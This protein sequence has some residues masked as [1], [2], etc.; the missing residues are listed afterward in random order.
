MRSD[1]TRVCLLFVCCV[2]EVHASGCV[3]IYLVIVCRDVVAVEDVKM[4][5]RCGV[6]WYISVWCVESVGD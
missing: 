1:A 2:V 4:E 6:E 5:L 3:L